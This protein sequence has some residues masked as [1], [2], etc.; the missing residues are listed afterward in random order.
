[1]SFN[2]FIVFIVRISTPL[3]HIQRLYYEVTDLYEPTRK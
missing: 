1:M 2:V 3:T